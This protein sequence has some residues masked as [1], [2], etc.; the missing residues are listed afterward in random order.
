LGPDKIV[1]GNNVHQD[2]AKHVFPTVDAGMLEHYNTKLL[3]KEQLLQDW[4]TM[5]RFAQAGKMSIF[6]IGV[7]QDPFRAKHENQQLSRDERVVA[8]AR[9]RLEYYL[10]CYLIGAQPYS[11]FQYGWGWDLEDGSLYNYPELHKP[12]GSPKGAYQRITPEGWEFK[13]EF[14]HASVWV[15]T[16]KGQGRISWR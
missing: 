7:E 9:E 15:D 11:Y 2:I 1:L 13:R 12:L 8:L 6:R 4:A 10:A 16:E 5:L 3:T 14:E